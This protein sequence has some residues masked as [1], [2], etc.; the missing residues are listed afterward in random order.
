MLVIHVIQEQCYKSCVSNG[1]IILI[2]LQF[3]LYSHFMRLSAKQ[4]L[5]FQMQ[6]FL[7][8][9]NA[10]ML[11]GKQF[12]CAG[13]CFYTQKSSICWSVVCFD[14]RDKTEHENTGKYV[15]RRKK[16]LHLCVL[17]LHIF[18]K[19]LQVYFLSSAFANKS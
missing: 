7:Q 12:P 19:F 11:T 16:S 6:C 1:I 9:E 18:D 2:V 17:F 4:F 15:F 5:Q 3:V 10:G 13:E 8:P 14:L